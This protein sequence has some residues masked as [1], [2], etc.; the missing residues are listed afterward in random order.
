MAV[1]DDDFGLFAIQFDPEQPNASLFQDAFA[2][3]LTALQVTKPAP[4]PWPSGFEPNAD[5][6]GV[7]PSDSSPLPHRDVLIVT[8]TVGEAETMATLFTGDNYAQWYPY[9]RNL[10]A[11]IPKVTGPKA[12][13]ND[14][15][16]PRYYRTLGLYFP[17]K[18]ASVTCVAVKSGLHMAYDGVDMPI[19]DLWKQ[20]IADVQPNLV[21]TT[22]TGGGITSEILLGDVVSAKATRFKLDGPLAGTPYAN[23]ARLYQTSN[24]DVTKVKP[25]CSAQLLKPNG[26]LLST[27]RIPQLYSSDARDSNIVSTDSYE[28]DDSTDHYHLQGL[29]LCCDM[30]DACLGVVLDAHAGPDWLAIRNASDPQIPN[31]NNDQQEAAKK[32]HDVYLRNQKVTTAG[33]L[34]A[35]WA[36]IL[37]HQGLAIPEETT[38]VSSAEAL[39][40]PPSQDTAESVLIALVSATDVTKEKI[41]IN[42]VAPDVTTAIKLAL[43]RNDVRFETSEFSAERVAF[44]DA[45]GAHHVVYAVGVTNADAKGLTAVY[46]VTRGTIVA[47]VESLS[48]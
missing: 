8:W 39:A 7:A 6:L 1:R 16:Y 27:P 36:S 15:K 48:G 40:S 23:S 18:I 19:V 29:G 35:C 43:D 9:R 20:M 4:I 45:I 22:G 28:Y 47:R 32:A 24:I 38:Y 41:G 31:P 30:G 3:V 11:F 12:P 5:P 17:F 10:N 25:M 34:V 33:S 2:A 44:T 21:I 26:D 14:P 46:V 13:F 42:S 37:V